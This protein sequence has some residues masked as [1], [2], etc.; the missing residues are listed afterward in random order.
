MS[1]CS[2]LSA[3]NQHVGPQADYSLDCSFSKCKE[4]TFFMLFS[5]F[6][7]L[8]IE[9]IAYVFDLIPVKRRHIL[10]APSFMK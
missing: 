5:S 3:N 4:L 9:K 10:L 1:S 6:Q 2:G 8:Y 7:K